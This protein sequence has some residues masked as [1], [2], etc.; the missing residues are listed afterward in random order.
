MNDD[1]EI[2]VKHR[3]IVVTCQAPSDGQQAVHYPP[4]L[5]TYLLHK[6]VQSSSQD[7]CT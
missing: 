5:I 2:P 7:K 6:K 4:P 3:S 1:D